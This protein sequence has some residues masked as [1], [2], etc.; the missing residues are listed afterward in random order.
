MRRTL[1]ILFLLIGYYGHTQCGYSA[2]LRTSNNYC[3]GSALI[4]S[5]LHA[6]QKILWYQ[7]GTLVNTVTGTNSFNPTPK[8][9]VEG[10]GTDVY[11]SGQFT[12]TGLCVDSV[13]NI[14]VSDGYHNSVQKW[15]PGAATGVTVAGGNG[16]GSD[17]NQL[18]QPVGVCVDNQGN[19]YIADNGNLRVQKWAPG[20]SAGTTVAGGNGP[21]SG[22]NHLPSPWGVYVACNGDI[23]IGLDNQV[24]KWTAGATS[25]VVVAGQNNIGTSYAQIVLALNLGFDRAGNLYV[26][27]TGGSDA[28]TEWAPGATTGTVL[29]NANGVDGMYVDKAGDIYITAFGSDQIQEWVPGAGNWQSILSTGWATPGFTGPG[30]KGLTMDVRG[31]LYL[32]DPET[33]S[34]LEFQR[35]VLI[36]SSFTPTAAGIYSATVID[37]NGDSTST[38]PIVINTPFSG[39]TPSIQ[40]SATATSVDLCQP[41]TFTATTTNP[42]IAPSYQWQVSDLNVGGDSLQYSNNLF[43]NSDRIVCILQTDTGCSEI[44]FTDTS[45]VITLSVDAQNYTTVS[46]AA[47]D[48][49][50]CAG[51]PVTFTATVTNGNGPPGFQWLVN[52]ASIPDSAST[53][54]DTSTSATQVIYCLINSNDACGLA[55]SNSIPIAIF[56]LPTITPD[57]TFN[58]PYGKSL[59][60]EPT[61]TGDIASYTWTPATGLSDSAV[62]DPIAQPSA[63]TIYT[64]SVATPGGCKA[65]GQI[66]VN[67]YTP[68]SIPNAFTPNGDGRN[69]LFY[70]L[71]GPSGSLVEDFAVYNR[72]GMEVFHVHDVGPGD[73]TFAW[74][75]RF[76]GSPLPSGTYVYMVVMQYAGGQRQLY[77][78]TVILIR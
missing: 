33:E 17:A 19:L 29:D 50:V 2:R 61:I 44:F 32:G 6:F 57:Q 31:N 8:R 60:L 12:L 16:K 46:I 66:T 23:Y 77:K 38:P 20:A 51:T 64:L 43:G 65:S 52:G 18:D 34:V 24:W 67:V 26:G 55:K 42:G 69:D 71:G 73:P 28:V 22:A 39:P 59:Q 40:I 63:T 27:S 30:Y 9:M 14:Y 35:K 72:T 13:G 5:S 76:H 48:T 49:A 74:D 53:Y 3:V 15:L 41:V 36:D 11:G 62:R 7:N 78:G 58:I 54:V 75:G 25:G 10:A 47:S 21:G 4:V 37:L 70:V 68:L 1:S 45:N 56:A